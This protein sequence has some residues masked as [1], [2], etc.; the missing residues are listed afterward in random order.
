[1]KHYTV[2]NCVETLIIRE[3]RACLLTYRWRGDTVNLGPSFCCRKLVILQSHSFLRQVAVF[4]THCHGIHSIVNWTLCNFILRSEKSQVNLNTQN[5]SFLEWLCGYSTAT[6]EWMK[7]NIEIC[8]VVL[9]NFFPPCVDGVGDTN[10]LRS[11]ELGTESMYIARS[12]LM[13][14]W[15]KN[16]THGSATGKL[17]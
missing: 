3:C 2:L 9:G 8:P 1:M 4:E 7:L 17:M 14:E 11:V 5:W 16:N 6:V 15:G 12:T 13:W 10:Y